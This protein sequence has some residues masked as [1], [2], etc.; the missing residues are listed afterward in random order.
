MAPHIYTPAE[1]ESLVTAAGRLSPE[2][3]LTPA[4]FTTLFGLLAATGLRIS[5]ALHLCCGDLDKAQERLIVR[6]GKFQRSRL[7][8]LHPTATQALRAYLPVRSTTS[9]RPNSRSP[10]AADTGLY[11]ST[12]CATAS[13]AG[14]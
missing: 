8:P 12:T 3:G 13:S 11:G 14:G 4:T 6:H 2:G 5:E 10:L 1:V 7:V 9:S